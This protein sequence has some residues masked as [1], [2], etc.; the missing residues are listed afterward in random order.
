MLTYTVLRRA[1]QGQ[2]LTEYALILGLLAL[3]VVA[4]LSAFGNQLVAYY[5]TSIS[6]VL[7][8]V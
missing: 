7:E 8:T 3:A 5:I 1:A 6:D 4:A 2:G